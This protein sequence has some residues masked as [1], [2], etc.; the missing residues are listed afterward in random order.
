MKLLDLVIA[1]RVVIAR[2]L[3]AG[4][5]LVVH[6][7][8]AFGDRDDDGGHRQRVQEGREHR[9]DGAEQN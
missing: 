9:G 5:D 4:G 6:E 2:V 7:V 1:R 3:F 8:K